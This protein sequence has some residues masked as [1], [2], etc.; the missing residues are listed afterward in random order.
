LLENSSIQPVEVKVRALLDPDSRLAEVERVSGLMNDVL[1][2]GRDVAVYT[3]RGVVAGGNDQTNI[4]IGQLISSSLVAVVKKL[5]GRPRYLLAKGGI[6]SSDIATQALGIKKA[7]VLGQIMPG[8][9]VWLPGVE[10]LY[11]GMPYIVFPGNVGDTQALVSIA[12]T[13]K[14]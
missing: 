13:L 11:P 5:E 10:S 9:P 2:S 3:S 12:M 14:G 6:T 8:V 7:M 1:T 4:H